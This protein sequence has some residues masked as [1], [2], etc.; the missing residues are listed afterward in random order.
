MVLYKVCYSLTNLY[1]QVKSTLDRLI[2]L[3]QKA[4]SKASEV[5]THRVQ[6]YDLPLLV[7]GALVIASVS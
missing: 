2:S 6:M 7:P 5:L 1:H 3:Y 4:C